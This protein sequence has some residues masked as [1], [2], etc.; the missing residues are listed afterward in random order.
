M[1][2]HT[3]SERKRPLLVTIFALWGGLAFI[4]AVSGLF[5]SDLMAALLP[6]GWLSAQ[7]MLLIISLL[8]MLIHIVG[9]WNMRPWG[10][11]ADVVNLAL[12]YIGGYLF[13]LPKLPD[14]YASIANNSHSTAS[15]IFP[16]L[17]LLVGYFYILRPHFRQKRN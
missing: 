16:A 9:Y 4:F 14:Q 17:S 6:S 3:S 13:P 1:R 2:P 12:G 5:I 15:I 10:V 8:L 7:G 11:Y